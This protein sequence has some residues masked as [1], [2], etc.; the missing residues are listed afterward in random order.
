MA[1]YTVFWRAEER[2]FRSFIAAERHARQCVR[3]L[4]DRGFSEAATIMRGFWEVAQVRLAGDDRVW[5]D[6]KGEAPEGLL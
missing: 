4:D 1:S 3:Q 2:R 5:T 6:L